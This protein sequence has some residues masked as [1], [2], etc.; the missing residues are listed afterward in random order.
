MCSRC[1]RVLLDETRFF[2]FVVTK[3]TPLISV[4]FL[5]ISGAMDFGSQVILLTI[6]G[7]LIFFVLIFLVWLVLLYKRGVLRCSQR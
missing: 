3:I 6:M 4:Q 7:G 2:L 1:R 5:F